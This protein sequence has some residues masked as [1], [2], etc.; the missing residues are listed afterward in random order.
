MN[1]LSRNL[2]KLFALVTIALG[3]A[4]CG[5]ST[6]ESIGTEG[7]DDLETTDALVDTTANDDTTRGDS[8]SDEANRLNTHCSCTDADGHVTPWM[9]PGLLCNCCPVGMTNGPEIW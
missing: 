1:H 2:S 4:A 7:L 3:L 6:G 9:C 8:D 5:A